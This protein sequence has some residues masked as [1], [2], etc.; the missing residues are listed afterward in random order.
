M[1]RDML[2]LTPIC[3]CQH[4]SLTQDFRVNVKAQ[5]LN[6]GQRAAT[7]MEYNLLLA[8]LKRHMD[9]PA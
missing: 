2:V 6:L 4:L 8:F 9:P 5:T 7:A 1:S 3:L